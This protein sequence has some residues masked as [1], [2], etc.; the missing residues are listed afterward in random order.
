MLGHSCSHVG[1]G[2]GEDVGGGHVLP[3]VT[4]APP[5]PIFGKPGGGSSGSQP[6]DSRFQSLLRSP[7]SPLPTPHRPAMAP[8]GWGL[9]PHLQLS[10]PPRWR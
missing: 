10:Y 4:E 8:R 5:P 2:G 9:L 3:W 7:S 1:D 6:P